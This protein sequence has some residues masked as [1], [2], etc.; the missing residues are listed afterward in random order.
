MKK[1]GW[2]AVIGALVL[3]A[4]AGCGGNVIVENTGGNGAGG[5]GGTGAGGTGAGGTGAGGSTS[6]STTLPPAT[7]CGSACAAANQQGC[8]PG[9]SV[10][11]CV[12]QC[13]DLFSQFPTCQEEIADLYTCAVENLDSTCNSTGC[14]EEALV[15]S[16]CV[17]GNDTCG[18]DSCAVGDDTSCSCQGEC[19]GLILGTDCKE[20]VNGILC[21]CQ[22]DYEEIGTCYDSTLT[23]D[24]LG[25]CCTDYFF[26]E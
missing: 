10:S 11:E 2:F 26:G 12:Y 22:I 20:D 23:C 19:D 16:D 18:T 21:S 3:S 14:E 9:S 17:G 1:A 4:L 24:V 8:L 25:G 6:S 15:F 13:V 7:V 5:S